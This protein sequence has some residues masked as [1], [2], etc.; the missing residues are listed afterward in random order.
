MNSLCGFN[1]LN[2]QRDL[3][4]SKHIFIYFLF[5]NSHFVKE[6]KILISFFP[7][8]KVEHFHNFKFI[9][10]LHWIFM[11]TYRKLAIFIL[12]WHISCKYTCYEFS[13]NHILI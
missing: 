10:N 2:V 3:C 5:K 8:K 12:Y 9:Q 4:K 11:L 7:G 6:K 13:F 1:G